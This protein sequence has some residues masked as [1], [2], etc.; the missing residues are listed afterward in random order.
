MDRRRTPERVE[1][2][3]K[4]AL[5][6]LLESGKHKLFRIVSL[7]VGDFGLRDSGSGFR[8]CVLEGKLG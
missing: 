5:G 8:E 7:G 3:R 6:V 2:I 4:L 1:D